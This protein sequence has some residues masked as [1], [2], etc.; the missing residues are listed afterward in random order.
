MEQAHELDTI[1]P[2]KS[3]DELLAMLD[4]HFY[5]EPTKAETASV[6]QD[7]DEEDDIPMDFDSKPAATTAKPASKEP[8]S[9]DDQLQELLAGLDD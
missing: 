7:D 6:A 4:Q 9:T 3:N 8:E 1:F 5:T 2:V